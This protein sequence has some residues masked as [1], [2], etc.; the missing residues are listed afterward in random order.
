[1]VDYNVLGG[2]CNR[3][4]SVVDSYKILK[5]VD[6]LSHE[7][8]FLACTLGWCIEWLQGYLLVHDDIMDN[9]QTRRGKPCWFRVPQEVFRAVSTRVRGTTN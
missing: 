8:A 7:D 3:G 5:G 2:K 1:M 9:S 6:V 4:L